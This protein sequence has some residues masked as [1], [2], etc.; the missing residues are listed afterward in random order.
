MLLHHQQ[1]NQQQNKS[2]NKVKSGSFT[3]TEQTGREVFITLQLLR[4]NVTKSLK[5]C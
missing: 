2:N 3:P 1:E 5:D 4:K